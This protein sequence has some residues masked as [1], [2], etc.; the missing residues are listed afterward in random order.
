MRIFSFFI[1]LLWATTGQATT[2]L[3]KNFDDLVTEADGIVIGTVEKLDSTYGLDQRIY[4][5][6][7]LG[8]LE[9][10]HG[11]FFLNTLVIKQDGGVVKQHGQFIVG[12]PNF[13]LND[14]VVIFLKG[15]GTAV[16][17]IVGWT[18]GVFRIKQG[19][20]PD[21]GVIY[22]HEGNGL[23]GING[24]DIIKEHRLRS[25]ANII[26]LQEDSSQ[27]IGDPA[28]TIFNSDGSRAIPVTPEGQPTPPPLSLS[29]FREIIKLRIQEK[30]KPVLTIKNADLSDIAN[31]HPRKKVK[32]R[33]ND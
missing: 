1:V 3:H 8:N 11:D 20:L 17:P 14:R 15:N 7:T 2:L 31:S 4:T 10:I 26:G 24:A 21:E 16:V 12:S 27:I 30:A 32:P 28:P 19:A 18:Q 22:D 9:V 25:H 33:S 29:Q 5:F 6:V 23:L 13:R